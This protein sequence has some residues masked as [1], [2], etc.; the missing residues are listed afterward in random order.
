MP[1]LGFSDRVVGWLSHLIEKGKCEIVEKKPDRVTVKGYYCPLNL[2]GS[3]YALCESLM[4]IDEG[5]VSALAEE[6]VSLK[7]EKSLSRGDDCCLVT[8]SLKH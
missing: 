4:V 6:D 7:I 8:F 5:L 3:N 2:E 1:E